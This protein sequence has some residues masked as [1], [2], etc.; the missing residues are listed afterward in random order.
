MISKDDLLYFLEVSKTLNFSRAAERIGI[1]QPSLSMA[2]RRLENIIGAKLFIRH[3]KGVTITKS[4]AQLLAH[5]KQLL[6]YWDVVKSKTLAASQNVEGSFT[7]GSHPSLAL[8]YFSGFLPK[9]L[10]KHTKL[11]VNLKLDLSRKIVDQVMDLTLD[12]GIVAN[13]IKHPNLI[14]QKLFDDEVAFWCNEEL[15]PVNDL[16][17]GEAIIICDPELLQT[18][19]LLNRLQKKGLTYTRMLSCNNLEVIAE[20]TL[21]GCGVGILP[22]TVAMHQKKLQRAPH[23]M[24]Y[25]DEICLVYRP[26]NKQIVAIQE[27]VLA[28][29]KYFGKV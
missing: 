23:T 12:L 27:I 14:I 9:L 13:P 16:S 19:W 10:K 28:I 26:E 29:K 15:H 2:I 11:E 3:Q 4:G 1:S 21:T 8:V 5:A 22:G 7:I 6:Q 17:S 18:Q 24:T 20:L 25:A